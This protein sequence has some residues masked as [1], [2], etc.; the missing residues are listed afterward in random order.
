M[1]AGPAN[2]KG[3]HV[4]DLV[5]QRAEPHFNGYGLTG[6][7][8][9]MTAS[10]GRTRAEQRGM[11]SAPIPE[12]GIVRTRQAVQAEGYRIPRH[13]QGTVVAI[14]DHGAAYAVEIAGLPGG[15]EVV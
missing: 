9:A 12:F 15:P 8:A 14:Y 1:V 5:P 11:P 6:M 2:G 13:T 3:P 7:A 10:P 4:R